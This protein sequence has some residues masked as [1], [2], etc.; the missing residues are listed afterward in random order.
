MS[1]RPCNVLFPCTG[2]SVRNILAE[3]LV[4]HWGGGRFVGFSA[5]GNTPPAQRHAV[6]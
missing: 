6:V 3:S 4:N 1:D 2:N 5:G